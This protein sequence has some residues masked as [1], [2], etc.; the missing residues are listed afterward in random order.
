MAVERDCEEVTLGI[1]AGVEVA[2]QKV[3]MWHSLLQGLSRAM[4]IA[5]IRSGLNPCPSPALTSRSILG[6]PSPRTG[7][8][9]NKMQEM[10]TK[11]QEFLESMIE[12]S[13]IGAR[14]PEKIAQ[15]GS[16]FVRIAI[17]VWRPR[18]LLIKRARRRQMPDS[19]FARKARIKSNKSKS[20]T[21]LQKQDSVG[22]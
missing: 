5:P 13:Y 11:D 14:S 20:K 18:Q 22:S 21:T 19:I 10:A 8:P 1:T 16:I 7:E 12:T 6:A 9:T 3:D 17:C 4:S 2:G 15:S